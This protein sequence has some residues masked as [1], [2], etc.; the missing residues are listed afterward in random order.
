[1]SLSIARRTALVYGLVLAGWLFGLELPARFGLLPI[2]TL[3]GDV[4]AAIQWWHVLGFE[5]AVFFVVLYGH[6]DAGWRV[7]W[8]ILSAAVVVASAGIHAFTVTRP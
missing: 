5:L 6:F 3:T 7:R 4:R 1:M 8:L 2:L